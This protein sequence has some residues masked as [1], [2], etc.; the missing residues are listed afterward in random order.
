MGDIGQE[1]K[2]SNDTDAC[3]VIEDGR[4]MGKRNGRT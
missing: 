3:K 2:H 4:H 1:Q